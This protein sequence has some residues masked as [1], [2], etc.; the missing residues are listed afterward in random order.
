[1][2]AGLKKKL[3]DMLS[4]EL[5]INKDTKIGDLLKFDPGVAKVLQENGMHCTACSSAMGESLEIACI[6]HG[7]DV[8]QLV[9]K[10][11]S[12]FENKGMTA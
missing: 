9:D 10:I 5:E 8:N 3:A 11:N 2:F 4:E 12:Y 1:M 7:L 6:V